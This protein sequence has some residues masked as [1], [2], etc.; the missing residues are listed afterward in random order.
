MVPVK[1][2]LHVKVAKSKVVAAEPTDDIN[3]IQ[4]LHL[5]LMINEKGELD[6]QHIDP[7]FIRES[8][9]SIGLSQTS[10]TLTASVRDADEHF[11]GFSYSYAA[12]ID[13]CAD[14]KAE[15]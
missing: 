11:V 15:L 3:S 5:G 2:S 4:A 7:A 12:P 9:G 1:R 14:R 13:Y 8:L 10:S 6:M